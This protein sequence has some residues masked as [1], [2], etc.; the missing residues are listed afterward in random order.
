MIEASDDKGMEVEAAVA[1]DCPAHKSNNRSKTF[2][3]SS[4]E[5]VDNLIML[6]FDETSNS[7]LA[8]VSYLLAVN[9]DIQ[10][11]LQS[12]IDDYFGKDTVSLDIEWS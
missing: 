2:L 1:T 11:R 7:T 6:L 3:L 12:E 8:H 10:T 4:R 5:I 9:P